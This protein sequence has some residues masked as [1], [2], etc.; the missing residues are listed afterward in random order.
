M[1]Q[2]NLLPDVK[3]EFL[4]AQSARRKTIALSIMISI[5]ALALTA[6]FSI[7]VYAVQNVIIYAQ[8][9]DIKAKSSQL[10]S[11]KDLGKYLTIQNQLAQLSNLHASKNN[12]SRLLDFLP[13]LNPAPPK[14]IT[15]TNLEVN[16]PDTTVTF[17]GRVNDYGTLT[18]FNDTLVNSVFSYQK[19]GTDSKDNKL[20]KDVKIT[21]ASYD[22]NDKTSGV[23]FTIIATYDVAA[24]AQENLAVTVTVPNKE[25]TNSVVGSPQAIFGGNQ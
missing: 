8:T 18:T 9:Q 13:I 20:F 24:F 25:T 23:N 10:N 14:N 21:S 5:I 2:L 11:V 4:H 7:Y 19:N 16:T 1:I 22:K 3:K 6:V 17:K 12:F 15:L